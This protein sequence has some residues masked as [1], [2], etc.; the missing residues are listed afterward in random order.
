MRHWPYKPYWWR[1]APP[2]HC[3][4]GPSWVVQTCHWESVRC[5]RWYFVCF[6]LPLFTFLCMHPHLIPASPSWRDVLS[7]VC[8][9]HFSPLPPLLTLFLSSLPPTTPLP[10]H[11]LPYHQQ[12]N[13]S[14]YRI[15]DKNG[16]I[17]LDLIP[18][19]DTEM[20]TL[21]GRSQAQ[22]SISKDD[23][24]SG[25]YL[26]SFLLSFYLSYILSFFFCHTIEGLTLM[27]ICSLLP[28]DEG[29]AGSGSGSGSEDE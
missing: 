27:L 7:S 2:P 24:A 8:F 11:N 6:L 15:K 3:S 9:T 18:S 13:I 28:D 5:R 21:I 26:L 19:D 29:E 10:F 20:R 12:T 14:N 16:F 17:V 25:L 1:Y 4:A 22:S 23:I